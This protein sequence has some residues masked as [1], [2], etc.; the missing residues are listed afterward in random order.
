MFNPGL[1]IN[2]IIDNHDLCSIFKCSTQGG[3][4]RSLRTNSL[5]IVTNPRG[6]YR[7][8]WKNGELHYVGMGLV[9]DQKIDFKQNKTLAASQTN[10]V[11]LYLFEA[12]T[13]GKYTYHGKVRLVDKPYSDTQ[14]DMTKIKRTVWVFPLKII[15][16]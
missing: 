7:D 11:N 12:L 5:V 9:G 4:R 1:K 14:D 2:D 3:M 10:G 8:K 16:Q 13:K 15:E 6:V